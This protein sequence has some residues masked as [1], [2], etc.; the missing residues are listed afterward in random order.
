MWKFESCKVMTISSDPQPIQDTTSIIQ[1]WWS[2]LFKLKGILHW[3]GMCHLRA[4][5]LERLIRVTWRCFHFYHE[6][7]LSSVASK[8]FENE[9]KAILF[10]S[11]VPTSH[12][13]PPA[14]S[15][16]RNNSCSDADR[17]NGIPS[18]VTRF[19]RLVW[20]TF[21]GFARWWVGVRDVINRKRRLGEVGQLTLNAGQSSEVE[22]WS[23]PN[24]IAEVAYWVRRNVCIVY[25]QYRRK[26]VVRSCRCNSDDLTL[27]TAEQEWIRSYMINLTSLI[28][29][30]MF[31]ALLIADGI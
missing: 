30:G 23:I 10:L 3:A 28:L 29:L 9:L 16:H 6:G 21:L 14:Q 26:I 4:P 31:R 7:V 12:I 8:W 22:R 19:R 2:N 24:L 1:W 5:A 13:E 27:S 25:S 11:T 20:I 15:H 18:L 17:H